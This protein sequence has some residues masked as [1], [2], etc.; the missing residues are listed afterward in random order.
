MRIGVAVVDIGVLDGPLIL[1]CTACPFRAV[2]PAPWSAE[3]K[4]QEEARR[5]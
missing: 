5:C 4:S 2:L 3:P 1:I